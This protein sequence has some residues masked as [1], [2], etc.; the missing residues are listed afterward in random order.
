MSPWNLFRHRKP[1]EDVS[2]QL[3]AEI[4]AQARQ[5]A[6]YATGGVPDSL[7]GRFEMIALHCY[8]VLRRLR[9]AG[10]AAEELAQGLVDALFADMDASLREMGAGD[11]GIPK[12]I[13]R[14]AKGFFGRVA[15][16]DAAL[17]G[18][19]LGEALRRNLFGTATPQPG[20]V[21]VAARYLRHALAALESQ[22]LD[23]ILAGRPHFGAIDASP[24]GH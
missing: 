21:E 19:D 2:R 24:P 8:L 14:M 18:D 12:R 17:A 3:Y 22:P 7:D 10:P 5:P 23:Q 6:F 4:V 13:K 1:A 16:Y 15:A 11:L 9:S 20:Q